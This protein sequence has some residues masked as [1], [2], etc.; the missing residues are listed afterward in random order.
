ME[1]E[2]NTLL[3]DPELMLKLAR[4]KM[5]FGKYKDRLLIDLPEPYVVWF[6]NKGFPEGELGKLMAI[7]LEIK[8]NGLEYLFQ[9]LR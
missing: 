2:N 6:A 7:V 8:I 3:S 5:P 9:P 4:Y 1:I